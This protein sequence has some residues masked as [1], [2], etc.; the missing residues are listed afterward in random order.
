MHLEC[1]YISKIYIL[2]YMYL[3][4]D[5]YIFVSECE[6]LM[7]SGVASAPYINGQYELIP[8]N[9]CDGRPVY[10]HKP[11]GYYMY[12]VDN[13]WVVPNTPYCD[14]TGTAANGLIKVEDA[15]QYPYQVTN[16]WMSRYY[17]DMW[18][19]TFEI[20]VECFPEGKSGVTLHNYLHPSI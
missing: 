4:K 20:K 3:Y 15:A 13:H 7:L 6:I 11:I 10:V 2:K 1:Q 16:T 19:D 18:S 14:V 17:P 9:T 8:Y 12:H 5:E